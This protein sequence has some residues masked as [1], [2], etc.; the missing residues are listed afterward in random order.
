VLTGYEYGPDSHIVLAASDAHAWL[1]ADR[2]A[3]KK[4][5]AHREG[6]IH[7]FFEGDKCKPF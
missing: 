2:G 1:C 6:L 7:N 3:N 5:P 4:T